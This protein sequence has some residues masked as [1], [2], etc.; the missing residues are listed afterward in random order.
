MVSQK[1]K[2]AI[3]LG[4]VPAYRIAQRAELDPSTLSKIICG[5]VKVEPGDARVVR[6]GGLLGISPED[7]FDNA[8][9]T[10][11]VV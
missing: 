10:I 3:K 11:H 1:L 9:E 4:S 2:A 8:D 5:I 7:C 6:V